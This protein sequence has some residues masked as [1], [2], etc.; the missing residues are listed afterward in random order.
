MPWLSDYRFAGTQP[1]N[2]EGFCL[3]LFVLS[4]VAAADA[5][6][7]QKF[8]FRCL[9]MYGLAFLLLTRARGSM[10]GVTVGL[11]IYVLLSR[12]LVTKI[13]LGL[14]AAIST[15]LVYMSGLSDKLLDFV[16]RGGEGTTTLTGRQPLWDLAWTFVS[17]HPLTGYGYQAFWTLD[18]ADYFSSE[19]HWENA[20]NTHNMYLDN[21]LTLGYVGLVLHTSVLVLIVIC[22]SYCFRKTRS[23]V[24]ALAA[25]MGAAFLL[26]GSLETV[27][28]ISPGP[29]AF[30]S[31][32]LLCVF[33][34]GP[35]HRAQDDPSGPPSQRRGIFFGTTDRTRTQH[36]QGH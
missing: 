24:F 20:S 25:A 13:T 3:L 22:G 19:L 29:F 11:L 16:M 2:L 7:R 6:P 31:T 32:L 27:L 28:L 34:L 17:A 21:I 1:W 14:A 33:C 30:S 8:L 18:T 10:M 23:P 12:S 26:V 35:K 15:L 4:S 5:D 36:E 9:A